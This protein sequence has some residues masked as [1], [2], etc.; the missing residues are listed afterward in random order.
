MAARGSAT[1]LT[2]QRL[3]FRQFRTE[4]FVI[5]F[6]PGEERIAVRLAVIVEDVRTRLEREFGLTPPALTHV[7]IAD[8]SELSNGWATPLPRDTVFLN[9]AVPSGAE[10]IGWTTDWLATVFAHEYTHVVHLDLSRSWAR[11]VRRVFGRNPLAFPNLWLSQ[12]QI[13][14]LAT[15][16]ESRVSPSLGG[17][18]YAGEFRDFAIAPALAGRPLPLDRV[19]GGLIAWPGGNAAYS[20]GMG[21]HEYLLTRT[22]E[23]PASFGPLAEATA[24]RLPFMSSPVFR[25][26]FGASLGS[27]WSDYQKS[28]MVDRGAASLSLP[29]RRQLTRQGNIVSGPRFA[30]RSCE[31]CP[32]EIVYSSRTPHD[33]PSLRAVGSDGA[34]DRLLTTRYLGDTAGVS[35]RFVLFDQQELRRNVG[36]YSDLFVL[37]RQSGSVIPIGREARIEDPD[38]ASDGVSVVAVRESNGGRELV[39]ARLATSGG[40]VSLAD[41]HAV[42]SARDTQFSAPRWSPDGRLVVSERRRLGSLPDLVVVDPERHAIV[43]EIAAGSA[44]IVTP[45]WRSD[46]QA[47]IA[48]ADFGHRNWD[49]YEFDLQPDVPIRQLTV[50][51]GAL[52]PDVSPD[53]H[54]LVYAGDTVDGYDLFTQT[55][56]S[57]PTVGVD[58]PMPLASS[59]PAAELPVDVPRSTTYSPLPTLLPTTWAPVIL[60]DGVQ[61][62]IGAGVAGAD[63]LTRHVYAANATWLADAPSDV[64]GG[65]PDGPDWS[66]AYAY[67]RWR[68]SLF[69]DASRQTSFAGAIDAAGRRVDLARAQRQFEAG[70]FLPVSHVRHSEQLLVSFVRTED[71]Y[72]TAGVRSPALLSSRLAVAANTAKVFGYSISPERGITAGA[73]TEVS[74]RGLGSR[75]DATTST[76]DARAYVPGF[77]PHHVVA[78]RAAAGIATG[79]DSVRQWFTLGTA[80]ASTSVIDFGSGALGLLRGFSQAEFWGDRVASANA[81]Y[82]LPL[83]TVERG[84]GTWPIFVRTLS[85]AVFADA[86]RAW[87]DGRDAG[88]WK[89]SIGGE[90]SADVNAGYTLP[91]SATIGAA[92][93]QDGSVSRGVSVYVR[94]G[95]SF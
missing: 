58:E 51:A 80:R 16:E 61:T 83:A 59:G 39:V 41:V 70:V 69:I 62:R 54:T 33:F 65:E 57:F 92:W 56:A 86:G 38:L 36:L 72:E 88:G 11:G 64:T 6:H 90:L 5:Y 31:R 18:E 55:Y 85:A 2:D 67:E 78:L 27:L 9:A 19:N 66:A 37:D 93:A 26:L 89:R 21:F 40:R 47:V 87:D 95:R 7:V 17:R 63:L 50:D 84:H 48:A 44:R 43:R 10:P 15:F 73:T 20:A 4:H 35:R 3:Q 29:A 34:G 24:A 23:D 71:Q 76:A 91:L 53:G 45:A 60:A 42:F 12:W 13:E 68:L 8:Q 75:A 25:R 52:W 22:G 46:G 49:L 30:P 81:E 28:L 14:G 82:R 1:G 79:D 32:L 77:G 94:L 74:R